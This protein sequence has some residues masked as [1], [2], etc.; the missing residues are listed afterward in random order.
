MSYAQPVGR[1]GFFYNGDLSVET[2]NLNRHK[3][4]SVQEIKAIFHPDQKKSKTTAAPVTPDP[5][6]H[7][8]EA[9][10]IHYG[11]PPSKDKA[12]AKVKLLEA[13]NTGK[14]VVPPGI[15]KLE[16]ELKKEYAAADKKARAAYKANVGAGAKNTAVD[17]P[18][19]RKQSESSNNVNVTIHLSGYGPQ[20]VSMLSESTSHADSPV[21]ADGPPPRKKARKA[22]G[23][24]AGQKGPADDQ[25]PLSA[26]KPKK[27]PAKKT[28]KTTQFDEEL[29]ANIAL[30]QTMKAGTKRPAARNS[31]A[32][33]TND[34]PASTSKAKK[35]QPTEAP[36][37]M[38]D[39]MSSKKA[40]AEKS[41]LGTKKEGIAKKEP[42]LKKETA[43]KKEAM[44]K[45]ETP[46][47]KEP[48]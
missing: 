41:T 27:Q 14:L 46:V 30:A 33:D 38:D 3:R 13:L 32:A 25:D 47:K 48:P 10:L 17:T 39:A 21:Q 2:S 16:A 24:S 37:A 34:K 22:A 12:R 8:Y 11:I 43:T 15:A 19:K 23:I 18:R 29:A 26:T 9:Q 35:V 1:D 28:S 40:T 31:T 7:W 6:A 5:V 45:K 44:V 42:G 36:F 20:Q 4:A